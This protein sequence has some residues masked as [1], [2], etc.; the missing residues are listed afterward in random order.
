MNNLSGMTLA[1]YRVLECLGVG[2]MGE[3][4]SAEDSKLGR[5]VALK[6][7]PPDLAEDF[8]RLARFDREARVLAA[9]NHPG[10]V[11]IYSVEEAEGIHFL[12][13][14]LVKGTTLGDQIPPCGLDLQALLELAIPLT[15]ALA[16]AHGQQIVHRD[17]KPAN[18]MVGS[19]G[20]LKV[21]DFGL[22][23]LSPES[24]DEDDSAL[25][26]NSATAPGRIMGT[27]PYM[28][29]EQLSGGPVDH[30]S[31]IFSL[32]VMLY[33][34][35]TGQRPFAGKSQPELMS[36]IL[37][38]EPPPLAELRPELGCG[39]DRI[40]HRC[41]EKDPA[42]RW[43]SATDLHRLLGELRLSMDPPATRGRR[44]PLSK[45]FWYAL[46]CGLVVATVLVVVWTRSPR[47]ERH[48]QVPERIAVLPFANLGPPG[49]AYF[50]DGITDEV[51]S[52]LSR[53]EG[54]EVI[55]RASSDR[56]QEAAETPNQIAAA[57]DVHYL[58]TA[59]VRW[60]KQTEGPDR[61]RISPELVEISGRG[62]P[63]VVWHETLD[64]ALDDVFQV[65]TELATRV[66]Q[67]LDVALAGD[68]RRSLNRAPTGNLAAYDAFLR[69]KQLLD[70]RGT[71]FLS[72]QGAA[73]FL[74]QAVALD[75]DFALAWAEL[76]SIH[77]FSYFLG[78]TNLAISEAALQ[79][80]E[81]ALELEPQRAES[82]A[83]MGVYMQVVEH[84][85]VRSAEFFRHSLELAPDN[86]EI[87]ET[88]AGL[89]LWTVEGGTEN[90]L[91]LIG[92]AQSLDPLSINLP[93]MRTVVL[94]SLGRM[95]E[96]S[97]AADRAYSLA[98]T[99]LTA[100][101]NK[102]TGFLVRGELDA[103]RAF[104]HRAAEQVVLDELVASL[105]VYGDQYWVLDDEWQTLLLSLGPEAFGGDGPGRQMAFAHTYFL[106]DD[107]VQA[108]SWA[109]RAAAELSPALEELPDDAQLNAVMG[110]ALAY[111]G[112]RDEALECG[113]WG[114]ELAATTPDA[115]I[116]TYAQLQLIR[117][118]LI[119]GENEL[120]L[121]ILEPLAEKRWPCLAP[122]WLS[123]EPM[124]DPLRH[125][126]RFNAL[127]E[128][129]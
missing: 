30:R 52:R 61:I 70:E 5:Q 101:K 2:G 34:L 10:I 25:P 27:V 64:A 26:T 128:R 23:R 28:S 126:P 9:L 84:D 3:V 76:S 77:S 54:L 47:S 129:E 8:E 40:I 111:L 57:L 56:F 31:D 38:D 58:L 112:R 104:L 15:D 102:A 4:Y 41:L 43:Q 66:A 20:M 93:Q 36:S 113:R 86:A 32:G 22:A 18:V 127:L 110:S 53:L 107:L 117:A 82:H 83:A 122:G 49:D 1:H 68:S 90:V 12:T 46:V 11:T 119:L 79:T 72:A 7:L 98:P 108:R 87:L 74:R 105:A 29:P 55:A 100:I 60:Q 78:D 103:A 123:I 19:N 120:A 124:Y 33:Q 35:A 17:L 92:R 95:D 91:R 99:S 45:I 115:F 118:H 24:S 116:Y 42:Q 6:V 59:T 21:L 65:Q 67:A 88:L 109:E 51:R 62:P 50:V 73:E 85:W 75:P 63:P 114:V 69:A 48:N 80:A 13:M 71:E 96:A 106:R 97:Q 39:L 44:S 37:R 14:E 81:R 94:F 89:L 121:D 125:Q 16:A